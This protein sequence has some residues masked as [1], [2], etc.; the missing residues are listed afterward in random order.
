MDTNTTRAPFDSEVTNLRILLSAIF[1]LTGLLVV[2]TNVCSLVIIFRRKNVFGEV[3]RFFY[4]QI[5]IVDLLGGLS[6]CLFYSVYAI[7][8]KWPFDEWSCR[9]LNMCFYISLMESALILTCI[10]IDRYIAVSKPLRYQTIVTVRSAKIML[11][12][13]LLPL[14]VCTVME[15][16]P[17]TPSYKLISPIC[18]TVQKVNLT[19]SEKSVVEALYAIAILPVDIGFTVNVCSL[20]I[21][22][23]QARA[24]SA[25]RPPGG[26]GE[27]NQRGLEL[28]GVKTILLIS[29]VN[30]LSWSPRIFRL[31]YMI[32]TGGQRISPWVDVTLAFL[33]LVNFWSNAPIFARTN[34][35]YRRAAK[36]L[37]KSMFCKDTRRNIDGNAHGVPP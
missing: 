2:A 7:R 11:A 26:Q 10:S 30:M 25:I 23:R 18:S 33:T 14:F 17:G 12:V 6:G 19:Y 32:Y 35:A 8:G 22:V 29:G 36:A 21:S 27:L 37:F 24:V 4:T 31:R 9:F 5:A 13:L 1:V 20:V 3:L 15:M 34:A 16:I 28:K